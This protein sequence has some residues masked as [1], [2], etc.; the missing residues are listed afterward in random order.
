MDRMTLAGVALTHR[1]GYGTTSDFSQILANVAS[2]RLRQAYEENPGTYRRWARRAPDAMDFK[3]ITV[4]QLSA[5]PDLLQVNEHGEFKYGNAVSGSEAYALLTFGRTTG[6]SRQAMVNDDLRAFDR[7]ITGFGAAAARLE[8][9]LVY[10]QLTSNPTLATDGLALFEAGT[11][12]NLA[13]GAGSALQFSALS[14]ARAAMRVQKGLQGEEL[15]LAP[16]R[17]IVPASLEGTAYQLTSSQYVP[18]TQSAVSEFRQGGRTSLEPIVEPILDANSVTAW[19]L[20][21][22]S[23]QVDGVE[24]CYLNGVDAP[25]IEAKSGFEVDGVMIRC[26]H[27]FAAKAID[28]RGLYKAVGA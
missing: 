10:A 6:V 13:T 27:D 5:M 12:K 8:N 2:K 7:V 1:A 11:H 16:S 4:A 26:R 20:A 9:R 19:Y 3:P 14:A 17:L 22:D 18:A 28:F 21:A 23:G 15:N 24:Y 25:V